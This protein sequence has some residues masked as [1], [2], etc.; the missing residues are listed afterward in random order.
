MLMFIFYVIMQELM[1]WILVLKSRQHGAGNCK[2]ACG[3]GS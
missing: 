2:G 3:V 1:A